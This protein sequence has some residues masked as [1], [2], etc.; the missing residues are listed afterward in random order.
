MVGCDSY[1]TVLG[2]YTRRLRREPDEGA[3]HCGPSRG[4]TV[5]KAS[6]GWSQT[7]T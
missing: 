3:E 1:I 2:I 7:L 6:L 5:A 4:K